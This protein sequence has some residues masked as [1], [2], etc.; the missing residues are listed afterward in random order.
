M[1]LLSFVGFGCPSLAFLLF[2]SVL[3]LPLYPPSYLVCIS[4]TSNTIVL[5]MYFF[6]FSGFNKQETNNR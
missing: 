1:K 4:R 5:G 3:L 2:H 6:I